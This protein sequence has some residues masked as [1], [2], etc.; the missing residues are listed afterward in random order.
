MQSYGDVASDLGHILSR[1]ITRAFVE[2]YLPFL[3]GRFERYEP[4]V[5]E[6][7]YERG[8]LSSPTEARK[9]RDEEVDLSRQE[10]LAKL[11][12]QDDQQAMT[13]LTSASRRH[14][15]Q[16]VFW[17]GTPM[18]TRLHFIGGRADC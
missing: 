4:T 7:T 12:Q 3:T 17:R 10:L 13:L 14:S 16:W 18:Y 9:I 11:E 1:E 2:A 6:R 5:L 8:T 15:A